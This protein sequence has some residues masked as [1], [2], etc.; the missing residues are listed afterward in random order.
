[1]RI[2]QSSLENW[3]E[4]KLIANGKPDGGANGVVHVIDVKGRRGKK[5]GW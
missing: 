4:L 1:V 2:S 5:G 3:T